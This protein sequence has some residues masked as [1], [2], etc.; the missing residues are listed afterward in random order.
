M[1]AGKPGIYRASSPRGR[2]GQGSAFNELI[3]GVLELKRGKPRRAPL[4]RAESGYEESNG[5]LESAGV[6]AV[7]PALSAEAP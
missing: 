5:G 6:L 7:S 2:T 3:A 1:V 4:I